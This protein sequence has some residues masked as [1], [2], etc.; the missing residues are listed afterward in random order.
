MRFPHKRLRTLLLV[1]TIIPAVLLASV[2]LFWGVHSLF[3]PFV[4]E[5]LLAENALV[6]AVLILTA[7]AMI[8]ALFRPYSGG[9]FLC[10]WAVP[11]GL[12]L[13]AFRLSLFSALYPS[14]QVGYDPIFGA[15]SG[16]VLLLGLLFVIRGRL[17]RRAASEAP[18]QGS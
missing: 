15:I 4:P 7:A 8:Y 17:S 11:F 12:I 6:C 2:F 16:L 5:E 18:A 13:H 10:I 3:N 9:F 14:W 1:I